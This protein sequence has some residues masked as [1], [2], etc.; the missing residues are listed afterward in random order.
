MVITHRSPLYI[1]GSSANF[2]RWNLSFFVLAK[3]SGFLT[4]AYS[5]DSLMATINMAPI[6]IS[7]LCAL[8]DICARFATLV[9]DHKDH[10][11][12]C[13]YEY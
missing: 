7:H 12:F 3:K 2:K 11:E 1:L 13:L 4:D 9:V 8:L 6:V 10:I 5:G